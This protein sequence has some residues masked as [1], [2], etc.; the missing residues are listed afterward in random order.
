MIHNPLSLVHF[1]KLCEQSSYFEAVPELQMGV[2]MLSTP[3]WVS[4]GELPKVVV[5]FHV[6]HSALGTSMIP[7]TF[8]G[9]VSS[10]FLVVPLGLQIDNLTKLD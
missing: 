9:F 2:L 7:W 4:Y 1:C 5:R 3:A 8:Q 10:L 6:F